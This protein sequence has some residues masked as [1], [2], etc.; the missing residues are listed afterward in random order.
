MINSLKCTI[1]IQYYCRIAQEV[2][3]AHSI[4]PEELISA[5]Q[6]IL[7]HEH[8]AEEIP[9]DLRKN[10]AE[11]LAVAASSSRGRRAFRNALYVPSANHHNQL[12]EILSFIDQSLADT[13]SWATDAAELAEASEVRSNTLMGAAAGTTIT[14]GAGTVALLSFGATSTGLI[15]P[16]VLVGFIASSIIFAGTWDTHRWANRTKIDRSRDARNAEETRAYLGLSGP[17]E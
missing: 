6:S 11:M 4:D 17:N 16:V 8:S 9:P 14:A 3:L 12:P 5:I 1:Y 13:I 15:A 7:A 10:C 2:S